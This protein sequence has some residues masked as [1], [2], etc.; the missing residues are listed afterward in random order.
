MDEKQG[1]EQAPLTVLQEIVSG[2][3][4]LTLPKEKTWTFRKL[5][6]A[7]KKEVLDLPLRAYV[8][9]NNKRCWLV[10]APRAVG[11]VQNMSQMFFPKCSSKRLDRFMLPQCTKGLI[12]PPL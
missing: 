4:S 11:Q 10:F 6:Q 5:S 2:A 1:E 12:P 3:D 7:S 9:E 8:Y